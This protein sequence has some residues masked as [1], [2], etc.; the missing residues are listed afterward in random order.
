MSPSASEFLVWEKQAAAA[1]EEG[2]GN[3]AA[4]NTVAAGWLGKGCGAHGVCALRLLHR[5]TQGEVLT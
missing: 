4:D 5:A 1:D 3:A 2:G